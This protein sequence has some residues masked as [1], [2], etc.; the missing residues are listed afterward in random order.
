LR[1]NS[2]GRGWTSDCWEPSPTVGGGHPTV[3]TQVLLSGVDIRL[4]GTNS[5]GR[6]WTSNCREPT[7]TVE[8][9]VLL[10]GTNSN[11]RG[12]TSYCRE[13]TP[14]V[15]DGH[16]TVRNQ[17]L[18]SNLSV[19]QLRQSEVDIRQS[20]VDIRQS[21][22]DIRQSEVDI[23]QSGH[24]SYSRISQGTNSDCH[25]I[26]P[27]VGSLWG[28]TPTVGTGHPTVGTRHLTVRQSGMDIQHSDI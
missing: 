5:N 21:E 26:T 4:L 13:P 16:P 18:Q 25:E 10:S 8:N 2:D 27:T 22:V 6:G 11:G 7:P 15:G 12:W 9:Q 14:M 3:G 28:S 24:N 20:E 19:D 17:L 23:R 1:T